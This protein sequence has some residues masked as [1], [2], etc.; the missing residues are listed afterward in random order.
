VEEMIETAAGSGR[1]LRWWVG[2][3]DNGE[4]GSDH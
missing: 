1:Q 3:G 4:H 2:G